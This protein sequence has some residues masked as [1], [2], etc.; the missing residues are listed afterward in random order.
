MNLI[1]GKKQYSFS[2]DITLLKTHLNIQFPTN[3]SSL[4]IYIHFKKEKYITESKLIHFV[5]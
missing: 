1:E 3:S 4:M 5:K 2:P